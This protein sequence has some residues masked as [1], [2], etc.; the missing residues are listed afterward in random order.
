[1]SRLHELAR[2]LAHRGYRR[3]WLAQVLSEVGDW[4]ARLALVVLVVDRTGSATWAGV[5]VGA[6]LAAWLGPG[7]LVAAAVDHLDRRT[8]MVG[9]DLVRAA[10]FLL[11]LVPAPVGV[12]VALAAV[13]GLATPAFHGARSAAQVEVVPAEHYGPSVA[14]TGVTQDV[15]VLLGYL[16]GGLALG[17]GD[18]STALVVNAASFGLSAVVLSGL[19]PLPARVGPSTGAGD[20][21][22][23]RT[24]GAAAGAG[25]ATGLRTAA[26]FVMGDPVV[27]RALLLTLVATFSATAS[28]TLLVVYAVRDLGGATW[29]APV[30]LAATTA[31]TL[32][33][34]A[35]VALSG[36][37][38]H[39]LHTTARL[40][41]VPALA[42]VGL[43]AAG[44]SV[45]RVL[46]PG[47]TAALLADGSAVA[48]V[49]VAATATGF[50]LAGL[51]FVATTPANVV[52]G[53]R[54]PQHLRAVAMSV[55][56]GATTGGQALAA[57]AA[58]SL[59]DV[60]PVHVGLAVVMAPAAV[61]GAVCLFR[62]LHEGETPAP[63]PAL[64]VIA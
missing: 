42:V 1:M 45:S 48:W 14:L 58:G 8:V 2:P 61:V 50:V 23:D 38:S 5:A 55:V 43:A 40:T 44:W 30:L 62:R 54:L 36:S 37:A 39:L 12:T 11:V 13:A 16:L 41:A 19:G 24:E 3:L 64:A 51:L 17:L 7:Q 4:A 52:G 56:V 60:V 63:R 32:V 46:A 57:V 15:T 31:L 18:P 25:A 27:R 59:A 6:S 33:G 47:P 34:T 28:E 29:V 35:R 22:D 21:S 53:P 49:G 10:A 9:T 26:A 20:G